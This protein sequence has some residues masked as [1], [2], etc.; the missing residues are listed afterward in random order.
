M[1]GEEKQKRTGTETNERQLNWEAAMRKCREEKHHDRLTREK[2]WL[3]Q[4][5]QRR[6]RED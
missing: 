5:K 1:D 3:T 6:E 2:A 4:M